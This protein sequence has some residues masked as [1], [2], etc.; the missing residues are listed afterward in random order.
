MTLTGPVFRSLEPASFGVIAD[1][2]GLT[3]AAAARAFIEAGEE[4]RGRFYEAGGLMVARGLKSLERAPE[5]L[6][7]ISEVFGPE[8]ENYHETLTAPR[9]FHDSVPEI[10][11]LSNLPPCNHPPPAKPAAQAAGRLPVRFP[12]QKNWHT[13][14]SYRRPPPDVTLLYGVTNPPR[15]QGQTLYADCTAAYAALD[16]GTKAR[17]ENLEGIHAPSW[18]GRTP[19]DVLRG[20]APKQLLPHQLPQRH[21]LVRHHPETGRPSL[22]ICEEKQMDFVEGPIAGLESGPR[23]EGAK[24]LRGL[25]HHATGPDF[26]YVH[27][28]EKGDLVIGDNRCLLHAATWYDAARYPRVMWRT[29]VMGNP[30]AAYA[31]EAKSWIPSEGLSPMTGMENA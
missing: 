27:E 6:V 20:A 3:P 23:G 14:Q 29:T 31:G 15:G 18:I 21:R 2:G 30:G 1:F 12:D 7:R 4:I 25:L 26:T 22:Y 28:W 10:L 17:I 8:V 5:L 19:E 13:D 9:F 11:V 24:L 16:A